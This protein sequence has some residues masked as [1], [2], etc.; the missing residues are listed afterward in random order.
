MSAKSYRIAAF[1]AAVSALTTILLWLL[2]RLYVSPEGFD[3]VVRLHQNST[4]L[5][6]LWV[7]FV[8]VFFA[9]AAYAAAATLLW[10]RSP[11]LAG[12]GLICFLLWGFVEL[13]G[14]A[15]NLFAVNFTWR[16]Q[17]PLSSAEVQAQLKV[18]LLG[19]PAVW[20]ALF[21]VLL[22]GFLLGTLC[23]GA[24]A[25]A[26]RGLERWVGVLFLLAAPLTIGIMLGGYTSIS[27]FDGVVSWAYPVLQPISRALLALWLWTEARNVS[28]LRVS[29]DI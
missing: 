9:L 28:R 12:F 25:V 15:T 20:D 23:F 18:L 13:I 14:V 22:C 5:A 19:F 21:F 1:A 27:F 11:A 17:Y 8:H 6:R 24:A 3:E 4:Y 2:P 7:N 26:G 29:T 16:A 10:R